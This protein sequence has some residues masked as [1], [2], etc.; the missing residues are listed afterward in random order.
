MH[1]RRDNS[2]LIVPSQLAPLASCV[3]TRGEHQRFTILMLLVQLSIDP[4]ECEQITNLCVGTIFCQRGGTQ[5]YSRMR[6]AIACVKPEA[7]ITIHGD[8]AGGDHLLRNVSQ[9]R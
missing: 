6:L 8:P 9:T 7:T 5:S 1:G 2:A 3:C 4:G